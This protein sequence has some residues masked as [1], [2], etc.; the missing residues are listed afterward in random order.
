MTQTFR[1]IATVH[2]DVTN[3]E[4]ESQAREQAFAHITAVSPPKRGRTPS[5]PRTAVTG[6][7]MET[8]PYL[9]QNVIMGIRREPSEGVLE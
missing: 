3:A 7:T 5:G 1:I 6:V 9:L 4:S 8:E 2:I